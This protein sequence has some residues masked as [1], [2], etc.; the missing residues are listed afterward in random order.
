MGGLEKAPRR[1]E[2][3]TGTTIR[4]LPD[5]EVFTDIAVPLEYY[6]D[7]M[8]RQAVVNAGVT[9]RLRFRDQG[10]PAFAET[11]AC[12]KTASPTISASWRGRTP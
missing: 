5:L 7:V 3:K 10:A 1:P 11:Q 12:M 6:Q 9:F 4:W 8:K 2:K